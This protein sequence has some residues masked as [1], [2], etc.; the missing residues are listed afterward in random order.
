MGVELNN[1]CIYTLQFADDQVA[2]GNDIWQHRNWRQRDQK[3]NWSHQN[4]LGASTAH[5]EVRK[6][7]INENITF[8]KHM[9]KWEGNKKHLI[10]WSRDMESVYIQKGP[11]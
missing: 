11:N 1:G 4:L 6:L 5:Y 3:K 10:I 7:L 8:T 2:I 9:I